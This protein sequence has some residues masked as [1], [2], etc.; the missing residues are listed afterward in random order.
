MGVPRPI[1]RD[2]GVESVTT[3]HLTFLDIGRFV[4]EGSDPEPSPTLTC[5]LSAYEQHR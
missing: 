5:R 2:H 1:V 4:R 3:R